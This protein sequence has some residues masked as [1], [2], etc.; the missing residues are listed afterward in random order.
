[1]TNA[2]TQALL[3]IYLGETYAEI[4]VREKIQSANSSARKKKSEK[5]PQILFKKNYFLPQSS[6]KTT[7]NHV[8]KNLTEL[9]IQITDSY[10]VCRYLERLKTF[11]LGGSVVQVVHKG[12]ENSYVV[13]NTSKV[14]LAASAL[15]I[16]VADDFSTEFLAAE[17]ERIK[18]I[19]PDANK[20]AIELDVELIPAPSIQKIKDYFTEL[21]FKIFACDQPQDL[22]KVRKTLL[23]AGSEGTKEEIISELKENFKYGDG[24]NETK[25]N[26]HFWVKDQFYLTDSN[27]F[28]NFD[29]YFSSQ[30]FLTYLLR[31]SKKKNL[32][33]F[34]LENW[35]ILS[36]EQK[37]I[38]DSPWGLIHRTYN[39]TTSIALH[40]LTEILIDETSRL[41]FSKMPASSEPGPMIAGRGV[42]SLLIDLFWNH[43]QA[44]SQFKTLFPQLENALLQTKIE[45]QFKVLEKGQRSESK[46]LNKDDMIQFVNELIDFELELKLG[47][48]AIETEK[49]IWTGHLSSLMNKKAAALSLAFSWTESMYEHLD[50]IK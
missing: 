6:L 49:T 40:P 46:E 44:D 3:A 30:D 25:T 34:D 10:V 38:W 36:S 33:H 41:Q 28:E 1:M 47:H 4:E 23:N 24:E 50:G 37:N 16:S 45:S 19:N 43:I 39:V 5:I 48:P 32:I 20:V 17:M 29:L 13:E 12:F 11:R 26:V 7:L 8:Q 21:G 27:S 22:L 31:L 35:M 14:S 9:N 18:K 15:V 42:K 2:S